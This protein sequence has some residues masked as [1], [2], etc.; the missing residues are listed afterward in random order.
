MKR[1]HFL[2][3]LMIVVTALAACGLLGRSQKTVPLRARLATQPAERSTR[4][5]RGRTA[6]GGAGGP[7]VG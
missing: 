3:L 4:P 2:V 7:R 5:D 6:I 1:N